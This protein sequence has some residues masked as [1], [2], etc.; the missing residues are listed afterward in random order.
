[1]FKYIFISIIY[2][3]LGFIFLIV[4]NYFYINDHGKFYLF[5][6]LLFNF[7]AYNFYNNYFKFYTKIS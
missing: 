2:R 4:V 1:M 5:W 3:F 7:S 6:F